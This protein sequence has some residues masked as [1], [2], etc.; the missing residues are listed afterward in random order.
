MHSA[1]VSIAS[2]LFPKQPDSS[3][4]VTIVLSLLVT[5]LTNF[6]AEHMATRNK[7]CISRL[8]LQLG[9]AM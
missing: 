6:V 9:V 4:P 7:D 2:S 3:P 5:E 8:P 1:M